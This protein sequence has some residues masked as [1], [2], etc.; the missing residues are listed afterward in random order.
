MR[1]AEI[2]Q[3]HRASQHQRTSRYLAWHDPHRCGRL[4]M[5]IQNAAL[6]EWQRSLIA[7]SPELMNRLLDDYT[8]LDFV[9]WRR[10]HNQAISTL[11]R[12]ICSTDRPLESI[13]LM[14]AIG[15]DMVPRATKTRSIAQVRKAIMP[16]L[17]FDLI[18]GRSESELKKII[19]VTHEVLLETLHVPK[20]DRYQVVH[21]HKRSRMVIEDTGLGFARSDKIVVLQITSRPRKREMKQAFYRL[22]VERLSASCRISPTD[23]VVNFV[24]N[25]DE[26]WS[27]GAGRAQFLTGDL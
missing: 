17:R 7:Q 4:G 8:S 25:A 3:T 19:D 26:D 5:R 20:H 15:G 23:V 27:F 9:T 1:L 11:S 2:H 10:F 6:L 16:L 12:A 13:R 18:E 24:T 22:L 14:I 21:E